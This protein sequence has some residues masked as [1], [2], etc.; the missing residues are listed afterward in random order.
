M[1]LPYYNLL[2]LKLGIGQDSRCSGVEAQPA[3]FLA[4]GR[5]RDPNI[6]AMAMAD[7]APAIP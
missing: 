6:I 1:I 4:F 5:K 7:K 3:T 2:G